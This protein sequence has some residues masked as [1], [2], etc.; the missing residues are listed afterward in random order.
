MDI[1]SP[2]LLKIKG[3]L[4]LL[5][6]LLSAG[7]LLIP[8]LSLEQVILFVISAWSFCRAYYFCFYVLENY[9]GSSRKYAGLW[10]LMLQSMRRSKVD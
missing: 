7:L 3:A 9:A 10:D 5:L 2:T 6:C 8:S 1:T 4:F